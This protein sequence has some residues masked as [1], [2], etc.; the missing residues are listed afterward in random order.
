M[1]GP[2]RPRTSS[3]RCTSS[4][5]RPRAPSSTP[6]AAPRS[7]ASPTPPSRSSAAGPTTWPTAG[8]RTPLASSKS[9]QARGRARLPQLAPAAPAARW[10]PGRQLATACWQRRRRG[11]APPASTVAPLAPAQAPSRPTLDAAS[12]RLLTAGRRTPL[13]RQR[14][15]LRPAE[16][17]I[18]ATTATATGT[19]TSARRLHPAFKL[20]RVLSRSASLRAQPSCKVAARLSLACRRRGTCSAHRAVRAA[21]EALP[22]H[23]R[24]VRARAEQEWQRRVEAAGRARSSR[25]IQALP[26]PRTEPHTSTGAT[27]ARA[28]RH[29]THR[30]SALIP[31][32]P[33]SAASRAAG[34]LGRDARPALEP[35]SDVP[36]PWPSPSPCAPEIVWSSWTIISTAPTWRNVPA[37]KASSP[38]VTGE[39]PR[40]DDAAMPTPMPLGVTAEKNRPRPRSA[41]H[42]APPLSMAVIRADVARPLCAT[43][44]TRMS[45][46]W[47]GLDAT[48]RATPATKEWKD[49]QQSTITAM[50]H[51][52]PPEPEPPMRTPCISA[53]EPAPSAVP[54][55]SSSS[56]AS[57][58]AAPAS[59]KAV[60]DSGSRARDAT[61]ATGAWSEAP[62]AGE[63]GT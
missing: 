53:T 11:A 56:S 48:P 18:T 10:P 33:A 3:S 9:P 35:P 13:P 8:R 26:D 38:D 6:S 28:D 36:C 19:A 52:A 41:V 22:A 58:R 23:S 5:T 24:P 20:L 62:S 34:V 63:P 16:T 60:A 7:T 29:Y 59:A 21:I 32:K 40:P 49:R 2:S 44:A 27:G 17:T 54:P 47:P 45:M 37:A 42:E 61:D 57:C 15:R 12:T 39:S 30:D 4:R 50:A 14:P 43:T 31:P 55:K 25:F 1:S 51:L 46:T